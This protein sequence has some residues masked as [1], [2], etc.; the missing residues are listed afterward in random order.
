MSIFYFHEFLGWIQK[1]SFGIIKP[2]SEGVSPHIATH[3][4]MCGLCLLS[5]CKLLLLLILASV[6]CP[7]THSF[8]LI[9][10]S[11]LLYQLLLLFSVRFPATALVSFLVLKIQLSLDSRNLLVTT[12]SFIHISPSTS[13]WT[14]KFSE[15]IFD[16]IFKFPIP[17]TEWYSSSQC[18]FTVRCLYV[19]AFW[20]KV[21]HT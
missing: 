8:V 17:L 10:L 12:S 2:S 18:V 16:Y 5:I 11:F 20:G 4:V 14:P 9:W 7:S 21:S 6:S 13:F 19:C 3:T 15:L 1:S